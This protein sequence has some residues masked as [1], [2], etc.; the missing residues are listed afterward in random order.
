MNK[1]QKIIDLLNKKIIF[2]SIDLEDRIIDQATRNARL[3]NKLL[4]F[5]RL[6]ETKKVFNLKKIE[7]TEK[8]L[9]IEQFKNIIENANV[10]KNNSK[11]HFVYL[12]QFERYNNKVLNSNYDQIKQIVKELDINFIDV[13]KE[14]FLKHKDPLELFPFKMWGHYNENGYKKVTNHI[15]ENLKQYGN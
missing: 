8:K 11:L 15:Y 14:V 10:E 9:P 7:Q 3:K 4:K 2:K 13:H 1:K 12:P 5:I 6:N